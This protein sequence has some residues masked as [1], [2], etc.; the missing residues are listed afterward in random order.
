M[1]YDALNKEFKALLGDDV[2][3]GAPREIGKHLARVY[4]LQL[5]GKDA[6]HPQ[7]QPL[8]DAVVQYAAKLGGEVKI[9]GTIR[10]AAD[11]D[12]LY[13]QG[14]TAPGPQVTMAKGGQSY[15]NYGLAF[16]VSVT[17][18]PS[19]LSTEAFL[20][21]M[22]TYAETI[23]M[24]WGGDFGDQDHFEYHPGFAWQDLISWLLPE[25]A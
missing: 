20:A 2:K 13:A 24:V 22:G 19:S 9:A 1:N 17:K 18:L 3:L 16:D 8:A 6:L 15:H 25:H 14:R 12:A 11:Q 4:L 5:K 23:G 10:T 7:L 21:H